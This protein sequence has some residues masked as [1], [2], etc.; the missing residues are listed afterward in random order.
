MLIKAGAAIASLGQ[1]NPLYTRVCVHD[2]AHA[3]IAYALALRAGMRAC[4][5]V[6]TDCQRPPFHGSGGVF[7]ESGGCNG[8]VVAVGSDGGL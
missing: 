8:G 2:C 1:S 7:D 5:R 6:F 3:Q 4:V